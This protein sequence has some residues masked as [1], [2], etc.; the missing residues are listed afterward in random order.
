MLRGELSHR[1]P[2]IKSSLCSDFKD[3]PI[4]AGAASLRHVL[5]SAP[6]TVALCARGQRLAFGRSSTPQT[7]AAFSSGLPHRLITD[8]NADRDDE[9]QGGTDERRRR[10][11]RG[12]HCFPVAKCLLDAV[13]RLDGLRGRRPHLRPRK[14]SRPPDGAEEN[15]RGHKCT[16][17]SAGGRDNITPTL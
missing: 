13:T 1:K 10:R 6:A 8:G 11:R 5:H 12:G 15:Q 17:A 14:V 3:R 2:L 16:E 9:A 7:A 4:R